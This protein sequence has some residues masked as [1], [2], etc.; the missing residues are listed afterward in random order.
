MRRKR[1]PDHNRKAPIIVGTGLVGLDAVIN[2]NTEKPSH[3]WVG[4]TCGNVLTILSYLGWDSYP[5]SRLND[6]LASYYIRRDL[7][8]WGVKLRFAGLSPRC[9]APIIVHRIG[10]NCGGISSHRFSWTCPTCKAFLPRYRPVT[11]SAV[12]RTA[13]QTRN[14]AVFFLDRVSSAGLLLAR[15]YSR[16]GAIIV[17]EPSANANGKH[18]TEALNLANIVKYS[19]ERKK[20]LKPFVLRTR[21]LLEI[22]TMGSKG[23]SYRS[24]IVSC[25][26]DGWRRMKAYRVTIK[27]DEA[28]AGDWCTAGII[29][30][31]GE[32]GLEGFLQITQDQLEQALHFGQA[33]ASWNCAFEGARGGMYQVER[34]TFEEQVR[35]IQAGDSLTEIDLNS[36]SMKRPA[37]FRWTCPGLHP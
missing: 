1:Q 33:L 4:G 28:G 16:K 10:R 15:E 32:A 30:N 34:E 26:T 23:L 14:P 9:N 13:S 37:S 29:H 21:P 35:R 2:G 22:V 18:L 19:H 11:A 17:F 12:K 36:T 8:S 27:K 3:L 7:K 6:G 24:N 25:K 20:T 5:V 31:S